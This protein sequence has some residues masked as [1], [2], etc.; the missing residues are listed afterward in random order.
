MNVVKRQSN[1]DY[2]CPRCGYKTRN[3]KHME[4]HL[5]NKKTVCP[6]TSNIVELT[7]EIKNHIITNRV[8]L[9]PSVNKSNKI[10]NNLIFNYISNTSSV[11]RLEH[12]LQFMQIKPID[13]GDKI[14]MQNQKIINQLTNDSTNIA[15]YI[16]INHDNFLSSIEKSILVE[17]QQF[18][19]LNLMFNKELQKIMI[20]RETQW[21]TYL[22]DAGINEIVR[23]FRDYYMEIY[24]FNKIKLM[25]G[26]ID[27][28]NKYGQENYLR[29]YYQIIAKF[30][31]LPSSYQQKN[32]FIYPEFKHDNEYFISD[33][34]M[35][36]YNDVKSNLSK[37][38]ISKSKKQIIDI[39]KNNNNY[40]CK[41]LD[42][43][44]INMINH[45]NEYMK[46]ISS[47]EFK[48]II[49]QNQIQ[50]Q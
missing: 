26:T 16:S 1:P 35:K 48:M 9:I 50:N 5:Y 28:V 47:D 8:Y 33:Y 37:S 45:D 41:N 39:I 36:L 29:E 43:Y 24:E 4:R 14:E 49:N 12:Y 10:V 46:F 21:E 30:D 27:G 23:I 13:Y 17:D 22:M 15:K 2:T 20:N 6:A 11:E 31:V 18:D 42:K 38:E 32:A 3:K 7:D 25:F 40:N 34:C 44:L 19:Q